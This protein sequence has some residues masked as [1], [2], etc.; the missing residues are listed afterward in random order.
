MSKSTLIGSAGSPSDSPVMPSRCGVTPSDSSTRDAAEPPVTRAAKR[1]SVLT[2]D[3]R[4]RSDAACVALAMTRRKASVCRDSGPVLGR[5]VRRQVLL[6]NERADRTQPLAVDAGLAQHFRGP[7]FVEHQC[8][9][10]VERLALHLAVLDGDDR[11]RR[12]R[13]GGRLRSEVRDP[14]VQFSVAFAGDAID[15]ARVSPNGVRAGAVLVAELTAMTGR[16]RLVT[17]DAQH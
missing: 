8:P 12:R 16:A 3:E 14:W 10:Q 9:Q 2:C 13:R 6:D 1:S 17:L 4:P 15:C 7:R 5:H 11:G